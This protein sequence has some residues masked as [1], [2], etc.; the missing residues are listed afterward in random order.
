MKLSVFPLVCG[1]AF[2]L[3]ACSMMSGPSDSTVEE[4]AR[5]SMLE[6]MGPAD[7]DPAVKAALKAAVD[8]ASI[9][10]KGMCNNSNPKIHAC[11]VDVTITMPGETKET[12]QTFVVEATQDAQGN[13][14]VAE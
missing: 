7:A 3:G 2:G 9:S 5:K 13:W 10:K 8:K 4:L 11:M 12:T 6:N 14:S 1:L